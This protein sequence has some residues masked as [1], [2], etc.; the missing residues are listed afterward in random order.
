MK[1][2]LFKAYIFCFAMLSDFIMF[3]QFPTE[4]E[5]GD[6]QGDDTP[7]ATINRKVVWLAVAGIL[8]VFYRFKGDAGGRKPSQ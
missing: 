1:T 2:S 8:F 3:A 4:D 6:L 7:A 5:D